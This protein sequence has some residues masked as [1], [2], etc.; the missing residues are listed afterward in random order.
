MT[1]ANV[2]SRQ[3]PGKQKR[4]VRPGFTLIELLVV[5]AIIAVLI[6]LLLPA[7]QQARESARRSQ[8]KNNLKQLAL[9]LH[10]HHDTF[11]SLPPGA[12]TCSST[13]TNVFN[14]G[15]VQNNASNCNGPNW[16]LNIVAQLEQTPLEVGLQLCVNGDPSSS[17]TAAGD[18]YVADGCEW[19]TT[20]SSGNGSRV[21][22]WT[23]PVFKCPSDRECKAQFANWALENLSKGNYAGNF[24]SN[25]ILS[26]QVPETAGAFDL[27]IIKGY[28]S[29]NRGV[30][31]GRGSGTVFRDVMDGTSNTVMLSELTK[32]DVATDGRGVW[33]WGGMG[34][35]HSPQ[36]LLPT[37]RFRIRS[38]P[39]MPRFQPS[40]E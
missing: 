2:L 10:N 39:A 36:G 23:P 18:P 6:A 12:S 16:A 22:A 8:C 27:A 3:F 30:I 4:T 5:I 17:S 38:R 25:T 34:G 32:R 24:G 26:F 37:R 13:A 40:I 31:F 20:G 9:A 19:R 1:M 7:V 28:G 35:H 15:G 33:I 14:Q 11:G 21:G 29:T